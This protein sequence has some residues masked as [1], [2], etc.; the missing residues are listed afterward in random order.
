MDPFVLCSNLFQACST[1][2]HW[3][4]QEKR[5]RRLN[6]HTLLNSPNSG[7]F[8]GSS[9]AIISM[10]FSC[11]LLITQL[12]GTCW[13]ETWETARERAHMQKHTRTQREWL[14]IRPERKDPKVKKKKKGKERGCFI[15]LSMRFTPQCG[16]RSL[17]WGLFKHS[18]N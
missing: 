5:T 14:E 1:K 7:S 16:K 8:P 15:S 12:E 3:L 18:T 11:S 2:Q 17:L 10:H 4:A 6:K 9:E 13:L